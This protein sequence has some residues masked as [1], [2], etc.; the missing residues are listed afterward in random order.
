MNSGD[1]FYKYF[2]GRCSWD[3]PVNADLGAAESIYRRDRFLT[4]EHSSGGWVSIIESNKNVISY[5]WTFVMDR[6][7]DT[8][9]IADFGSR[10]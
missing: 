4:N 8:D 5:D 7:C 6:R 10:V 3:S 1:L 9:R 2:S